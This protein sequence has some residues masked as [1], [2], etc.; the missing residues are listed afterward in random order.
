MIVG[1][2]GLGAMGFPMAVNLLKAGIEVSGYDVSEC[3]RTRFAEAGGLACVQIQKAVE[4]AEIILMSLPNGGIVEEVML[5]KDGILEHC[6]KG[7]CIVD[8]SSVDPT[9]SRRMEKTA[10]KQGILYADAPVSGGVNGAIAGT[11][12]IMFG[13]TEETWNRVHSVLSIIGKKLVYVGSIGSGDAIKLVN[14]MML[15]CNMAAVAEAV[16]LGQQLGLSMKVIQEIVENSSGNSYVFANKMEHY[17]IPGQY[18]GGFSTD[19]QYKD[20]NL[21]LEAAREIGMALPMTTMA[22]QV[23]AASKCMGNG[24]KDISSAILLWNQL[25]IP[26]DKE[27][28][29]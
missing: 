27:E 11:L 17:I 3:Q 9:T 26:E 5:S 1:M 6:P 20:L 21:A 25:E 12:T 10:E 18:D 28:H 22:S 8:L 29:K 15:G 23:F 2:I 14:N 19:L 24:K 7:C 13:G 16:K 4:E